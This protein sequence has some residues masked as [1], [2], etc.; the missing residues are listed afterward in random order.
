MQEN[1]IN[2]FISSSISDSVRSSLRVRT[3]AKTQALL[4]L[5]ALNSSTVSPAS[6]NLHI[7][8]YA[9]DKEVGV[10]E[11]K[12]VERSLMRGFGVMEEDE[13]RKKMGF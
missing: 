10:V 7:S 8:N 12:I 13:D 2:P 3:R 5:Q 4:K 1:T 11:D 6:N 9:A